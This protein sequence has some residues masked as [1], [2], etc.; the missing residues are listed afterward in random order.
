MKE[1]AIFDFDGT[2]LKGDCSDGLK[3][4]GETIY[5]GLTRECIQAGFSKK[6][7]DKEAFKAFETAYQE[8]FMRGDKFGAH[9]DYVGLFEGA[10]VEELTDFCQKRFDESYAPFLFREAI[11]EIEKLAQKG[12]EVHIVSAS[13][14]IFVRCADKYL[15]SV[16]REN[17]HGARFEVEN[18]H[19]TDKM[20]EPVPYGE[21]KARLMRALEKEKGAKT[22][23]GYGDNYVI[24][25][26]FLNEILAQGGEA[27]IINFEQAV[28]G[29]HKVV[30]SI[31]DDYIR[32]NF[33]R[34]RG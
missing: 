18:N 28:L 2:I 12:V 3:I 4:E 10:N 29:G 6:Y 27:H 1:L 33:S 7:P 13:L 20:I 21:G 30:A 14:E 22:L 32:H 25:G 17:I 5:D 24:D 8:K 31:P 9:C 11:E 19:L 26:Y 15:P 34:V 16:K 23:Y